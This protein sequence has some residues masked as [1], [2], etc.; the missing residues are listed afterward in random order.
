MPPRFAIAAVSVLLLLEGMVLGVMF[1][2]QA[3]HQ[4]GPSWWSRIVARASD[5][6]HMGVAMATGIAIFGAPRLSRTLADMRAAARGRRWPWLLLHAVTFAIFFVVT[7]RLLGDHAGPGRSRFIPPWLVTGA[8]A[9]AALLPAALGWHKLMALLRRTWPVLAAGAA[10]GVGAWAAGGFTEDQLWQPLRRWTLMGTHSLLRLVRDDAF[11]GADEFVV[12][13]PEF[14]VTV[15]PVCSGYEG[16]GLALVFLGGFLWAFR[17][18]LRF[19][20]ALVLLPLGMLVVW[21]GNL[22]RLAVLVLVGTVSPTIAVGG[23]HSYA[24]S[25]L[26]CALVFA[27]VQVARH[28]RWVGQPLPVEGGSVPEGIA[29][30]PVAGSGGG[31]EPFLVPMLAVLATALVT[32]VLVGGVVDW[33]YPLR[34]AVAAL[35]LVRY[36]DQYRQIFAEGSWS[37]VF[38]GG[39][40]FLVWLALVPGQPPRDAA[41][42]AGLEAA[43]PAAATAWLVFRALGCVVM[44]PLIEELA[45]RGYLLRRLARADFRTAPFLPRIG[46]P[47]VA[48]SLLFGLLH[49]DVWAGALAGAAYALAAGLRG[50]LR[51][52]VV[53]HAVTNL[54][55]VIWG[56][57]TGR[58]TLWL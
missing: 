41:L 47:L 54:L 6:P 45:F 49:G 52:A 10:I 42:A 44:A 1:H 13:L 24:G 20:A 5:V 35:V 21:V 8:V 40:V 39:L 22:V 33:F 50:H 27:L 56:S 12:G 25:V 7:E 28:T 46:L 9:V 31:A 43:A 23:F 58:W 30:A 29:L 4:L 26:F 37:G 19:P 15:D 14:S 57:A 16:I 11:V 18:E 38:V 2:T 3:L 51:D 17:R 53:A 55:L 32:G 48:S 36:R 34:V